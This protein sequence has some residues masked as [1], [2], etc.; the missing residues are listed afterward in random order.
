V[1]FRLPFNLPFYLNG[2]TILLIAFV[3]KDAPDTTPGNEWIHIIQ[4]LECGVV[5]F[6]PIYFY[7]YFKGR[8]SGMN[9]RAAYLN[10][11]FEIDS[12][13]W[14]SNPDDRP[15]YYWRSIS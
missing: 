5:G 8:F 7:E 14:Q 6:L 3:S 10:I 9:H 15:A 11:R 4:C 1:I 2:I 12:V 13:A